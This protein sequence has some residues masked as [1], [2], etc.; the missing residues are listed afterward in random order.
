MS[1]LVQISSTMASYLMFDV[2]F[3]FT[4]ITNI[5]SLTMAKCLLFGMKYYDQF[6]SIWCECLFIMARCGV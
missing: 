6:S 1:C 3:S 5:V 2:N 4:M